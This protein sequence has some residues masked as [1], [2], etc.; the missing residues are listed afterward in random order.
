MHLVVHIHLC[1]YIYISEVHLKEVGG[2]EHLLLFPLKIEPG[3]LPC[4]ET[5]GIQTGDGRNALC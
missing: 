3:G 4:D 2:W 1:I 5:T